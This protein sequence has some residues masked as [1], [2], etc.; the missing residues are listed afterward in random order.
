MVVFEQESDN[1]QNKWHAMVESRT[2]RAISD[3]QL[4]FGRFSGGAS[5]RVDLCDLCWTWSGLFFALFEIL[6]R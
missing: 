4:Q 6:Y 2:L 3:N 5:C 1:L